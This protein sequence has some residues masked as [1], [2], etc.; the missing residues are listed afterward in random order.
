MIGKDGISVTA[1]KGYIVRIDDTG[2]LKA[3]KGYQGEVD[4]LF[5]DLKKRFVT[6]AEKQVN[7]EV[8]E[9]VESVERGVGEIWELIE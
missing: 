8:W 5:C 2:D 4:F 6:C 7:G 9:Y 3:T 1:Q